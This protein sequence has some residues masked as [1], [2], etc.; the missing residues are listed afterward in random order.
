MIKNLIAVL[1]CLVCVRTANAQIISNVNFDEVK[2]AIEKPGATRYETLIE[3][4]AKLDTTLTATDHK[5]LYYGQ[6]FQAGYKPYGEG[7]A[8]QAA[9]KILQEGKTDEAISLTDAHL[10]SHPVSME[11]IYLKLM[12]LFKQDKKPEMRPYM[13]L[14]NGLIK[15]IVQSG[16]GKTAETAMVVASITDEYTV[17][18]SLGVR[19]SQQSL[20]NGKYPCDKM[21]LQAN[22]AGLTELFFN[23]SKP[24]DSLTKGMK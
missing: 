9:R 4:A 10:K 11:A 14:L 21:T 12:I 16:D 19:A 24:M 23:V 7:M 15:A 2:A 3:R 17:M 13:T 18:S 1:L 6:V 8:L 5:L 22:N 20:I